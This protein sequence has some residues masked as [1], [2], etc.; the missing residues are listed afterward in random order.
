MVMRAAGVLLLIA[1]TVS[2]AGADHQLT[3]TPS[4]AL[5]KIDAVL[6]YDADAVKPGKARPKPVAMGK[7]GE[8]IALPGAGPFDVY[9]RP[10]GQHEVRA[11]AMINASPGQPKELKLGEVFGT[12]QVFQNDNS[13]RL[14]SIVLTDP[15]DAGP[16][17]KGH[18]PIQIGT[19]YREELVV[20]EGFYAVWLVP[21]NGA[22][23][24]RIAERVRVLPGKN[25]RVG[26]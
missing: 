2:A 18:I 19:D 11:A 12:L 5:P 22:R 9:V 13:P 8:A 4:K 14:G 10:S 23:A 6:V 16:D 21:G 1:T 3:V 7:P 25:V 26:D 24:Q 20:P 17:E 15:F